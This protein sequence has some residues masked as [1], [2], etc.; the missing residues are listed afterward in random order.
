VLGKSVNDSGLWK[1]VLIF[2]KMSTNKKN[3]GNAS[4]SLIIVCFA[5]VIFY[6][7]FFDFDFKRAYDFT[8]SGV[9]GIF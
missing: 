9:T 8:V 3:L 4:L 1:E 6:L 5:V 2:K 7:G